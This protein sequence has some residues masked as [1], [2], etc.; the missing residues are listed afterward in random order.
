MVSKNNVNKK[1]NRQN[2]FRDSDSLEGYNCIEVV[3]FLCKI[4]TRRINE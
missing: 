4:K 2:R 3:T 1:S